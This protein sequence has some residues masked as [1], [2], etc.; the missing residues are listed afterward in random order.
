VVPTHNRPVRLGRLLD[1]LRAQTFERERFEVIVIDD[2]STVETSRL[3]T[4]WQGEPGLQL[5]VIRH[6]HPLGPAAARNAGWRAATGKVIAFTDDDCEPAADWLLAGVAGGRR[7]PGSIVQGRTVPDPRELGGSGVRSYTVRVDSLGP[8]YETCNIFYPRGLLERLGGFDERFGPR[9]A[10]EDTDLAWRALGLGATAVYAPDA[11]VV[12]AVERL[13]VRQ[14]L[15]HAG[16]WSAAMRVYRDHPGTR[17]M[18]YRGVFWNVWHYLLWRSL[19]GLLAPAWLR[20]MIV[21]RHLIELRKRA[22]TAGAGPS[23]IPFLILL[24]TVECWAIARGAIRHR[25]LVL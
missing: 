16:R 14:A 17:S 9:P 2:G 11:V 7:A 6:G 13:T 3:L 12:H 23:A 15:A 10:A 21:T 19:V 22:R 18:L 25:T 5:R 4:A 8:Q 20:R 1:G 24:D